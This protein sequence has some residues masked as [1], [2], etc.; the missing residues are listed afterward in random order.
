MAVALSVDIFTITVEEESITTVEESEGEICALTRSSACAASVG[1]R[2]SQ[3]PT[4]KATNPLFSRIFLIE[5][6]P[7]QDV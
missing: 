7:F 3:S 5:G 2:M 1:H 4:K 6:H